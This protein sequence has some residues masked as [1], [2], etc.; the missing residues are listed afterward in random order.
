MIDF[1]IGT[2]SAFKLS[3]EEL[4]LSNILPLLIEGENIIGVYATPTFPVI[5]TDKR[6]II[7]TPF[8][9]KNDYTSLPYS[10]ITA[11]SVKTSGGYNT[12]SGLELY[13]TGL[14]RIEFEFSGASD[15]IEIEKCIA[16]YALK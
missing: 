7:N 4:K 11:F 2:N 3:K 8:R 10:K 12:D 9:K 13:F 15:I 5:F 1:K 16:Q 6:I 14:G